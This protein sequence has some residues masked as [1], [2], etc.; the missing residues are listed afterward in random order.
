MQGAVEFCQKMGIL[1]FKADV[2]RTFGVE[3]RRG[4]ELLKGESSARRH[5]NESEDSEKRGRHRIISLKQIREIER[6]LEEESMEGRS[7]TWEQLGYEIGLECN[8]RT[9][10]RAMGTMKYHKCIACKKE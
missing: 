10:K 9:V 5:H 8:G 4:H 2:F 1:F 3:N 6:I 7:L